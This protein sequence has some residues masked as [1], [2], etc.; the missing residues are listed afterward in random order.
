MFRVIPADFLQDLCHL[1]EIKN[2]RLKHANANLRQKYIFQC[3]RFIVLVNPFS[4]ISVKYRLIVSLTQKDHSSETI[5]YVT[6]HLKPQT[7]KKTIVLGRYSAPLLRLIWQLSLIP[8]TPTPR[9]IYAITSATAIWL[10]WGFL[11]QPTVARLP[12]CWARA[13]WRQTLQQFNS[14]SSRVLYSEVP[15]VG[16]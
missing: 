7:I 16:L 9:H 6:M 8:P 5:Y 11:T 14:S 10:L 12:W 3:L 1:S 15:S 2:S 13:Y 4:N